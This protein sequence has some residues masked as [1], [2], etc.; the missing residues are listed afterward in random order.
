MIY[1][2]TV[3]PIDLTMPL[4]E[5]QGG[6][7]AKIDRSKYLPAEEDCL[8]RKGKTREGDKIVLNDYSGS[9]FPTKKIESNE[10]EVLTIH[11]KR[12]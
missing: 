4:S 3:K 6:K 12:Q 2:G 7:Y 1:G 11:I 10:P 8:K 9:G 5:L